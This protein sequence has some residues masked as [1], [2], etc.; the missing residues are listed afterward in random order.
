MAE[1]HEEKQQ[2]QHEGKQHEAKQPELPAGYLKP[3]FGQ[4]PPGFKPD[5][6]V[7]PGH[8]T[9]PAGVFALQPEALKEHDARVK[10]AAKEAEKAK[11]RA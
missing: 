10:E 1:K 6:L 3:A 5:P 11:A 4:I 7:I 9:D 2:S 8:E